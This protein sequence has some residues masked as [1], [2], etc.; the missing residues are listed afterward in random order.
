MGKNIYE[1]TCAEV[2]SWFKDYDELAKRLVD[3]EVK[4]WYDF[5]NGSYVFRIN[6]YGKHKL[7][8]QLMFTPSYPPVLWIYNPVNEHDNDELSRE[9]T[10]NDEAFVKLQLTGI[11]DM[12]YLS[13]LEKIAYDMGYSLEE[14]RA[15][16]DGEC[17]TADEALEELANA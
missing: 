1:E 9:L 8:I 15:L 16:L 7:T 11:L 3:D 12:I 2:E 13:A 10:L 4:R 5:E 17:P 6:E 14:T